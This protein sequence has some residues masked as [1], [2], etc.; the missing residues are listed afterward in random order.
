MK[1]LFL[2]DNELSGEIP[3]EYERLWEAKLSGNPLTG[4]VP[5]SLTDL[6]SY[7]FSYGN[8]PVQISYP[9]NLPVCDASSHPGDEE[10]LIAIYEALKT[11]IEEYW[12]PGSFDLLDNWLGRDPI[13]E[14]TG[15]SVDL[16]GRVVGLNL[17]QTDGQI[18]M[19]GPLPPELFDLASLKWLWLGEGFPGERVVTDRLQGLRLGGFTG[20]VPTGKLVNLELVDFRGTQVCLPKRPDE[21]KGYAI[22]CREMEALIALN[23]SWLR[24]ITGVR[25][26]ETGRVTRLR[27]SG[28]GFEGEI[29]PELG[30]LV[31]LESLILESSQLSGE[32]PRELGNLVNLQELRL[33]SS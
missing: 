3:A 23:N 11:P 4:C 10:A 9:E 2:Q 28:S 22:S 31:N 17:T 13:G 33:E 24:E 6:N 19:R 5:D 25:T 7:G 18:S 20:E 15:V 14:W 32:I 26:D 21:L 16:T 30:N 1:R 12:G 8:N 29:P 27:I